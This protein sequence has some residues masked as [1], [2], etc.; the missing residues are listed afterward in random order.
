MTA[1][2]R[3]TL[4][5]GAGA[6]GLTA[7]LLLQRG[8]RN[9][10][11]VEKDEAVG[12]LLRSFVQDEVVFDLG[13][14]VLFL[15]NPGPA[16]ALAREMLAGREIIRR[17]FAYAIVAGGREWR[18]PNHLDVFS[19]PPA[20][21]RE[22]LAA[23]L[24][25]RSGP[26]PEPIPASLELAEKCGPSLYNLLFRDLFFKK[27]LLPPDQLHHH[28]LLRVDRTARNEKEPFVPR[29]K[30]AALAGAIRR[31]RQTYAYPRG[32]LEVLPRALHEA[33]QAAGGQTVTGCRDLSLVRQD[34]RITAA[35]VAGRTVDVNEVVFTAPLATLLD[36]LGS[37]APRPLSVDM[38]ILF[39]TYDLPGQ[40]PK[41]PYVYTYHPEPEYV[42]NRI[43]YPRSIFRELS[44]P[45]REGLCLECN[46]S[47]AIARMSDRE[48][49]ERA[50]A[51]VERL[52]LYPRRSLRTQGL[53]AL[54]KAMPVYG[55]DYEA[56]LDRALR[57]VR[58]VANLHAVG[59]Q[60]GSYFCLTPGALSQG[61]KIAAHLLSGRPAGPGA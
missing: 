10:L 36:L 6:T 47:E 44:P 17:P 26:P 27:T 23:L 42:F 24:K 19:Y 4:I 48:L 34:G 1:Q 38:R 28:W 53:V 54:P 43:Y 8:G 21:Q 25:R 14:H 16:E 35:T 58:A 5:V 30:L 2:A 61:Q 3:R 46:V 22:I 49:I 45:G 32:G 57:D 9:C 37:Q 39:L 41:R 18:F 15:D 31:L 29:G 20:Y 12:G 33:Y 59:R 55:L 56:V 60:G 52:G 40:P 11:I 50:A 51:D 13:P 7:G